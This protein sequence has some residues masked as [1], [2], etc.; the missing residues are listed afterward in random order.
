MSR[1]PDRFDTPQ[2]RR[3]CMATMARAAFG[4]AFAEHAFA[5]APTGRTAQSVITLFMDGGMS[6]IDTF[7][8]KPGSEG[9][10]P[11]GVIRTN[12]PGVAFGEGLERLATM[13]DRLAVLRSVVVKAADHLIARYMFR[14][15]YG[16]T[17]A[18]THPALGSWAL[19][20]SEYDHDLPGYILVG[21]GNTHPG[22]GFLDAAVAP[23]S[24][25]DPRT[26]PPSS[27]ELDLYRRLLLST[28]VDSS[29]RAKYDNAQTRA[30]DRM[31]ARAVRLLGSADLQ[32]FDLTKEPADVRA[33]YGDNPFG[34]GCLLARRLV[35]AGVRAIDV[36]LTGWDLHADIFHPGK[37]PARV[38]T[39]D[40]GLSALLDDLNERGLLETTLVVVGTEFGRTLSINGANGR[41]HHPAAFSCVVAGAGVKHG[42]VH[43]AT[44]ER[45]DPVEGEMS[46]ADL[47]KT[48]AT[49]A[50]LPVDREFRAP[51][52]RPFKI[53]GE[54]RVVRELLA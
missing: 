28:H 30:Y 26:L 21:D 27:S 5:A 54:G 18:I 50:G 8:P 23:V 1:I 53:G 49:A 22:C 36:D 15:S 38:A 10:G 43:G 48:I 40:H 46:L 41:D 39:L 32:A 29:F 16:L 17:N 25:I 4:V 19:T 34:Q 13:A 52:G 11:T 12:V 6:Q 37:G 20:A 42:L 45:G 24:I 31:Y 51:N 33:R 14:T 44:D 3:A 2:S 47:N 7:D 35:E 9:Q